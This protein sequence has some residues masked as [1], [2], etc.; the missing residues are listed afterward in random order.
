MNPEIIS[1]EI[2]PVNPPI[3]VAQLAPEE[4]GLRIRKALRCFHQLDVRALW[5]DS[6][7]AHVQGKRLI[8]RPDDLCSDRI[9]TNIKPYLVNGMGIL[10]TMFAVDEDLEFVHHEHKF[11][12]AGFRKT[13][14]AELLK[15]VEQWSPDY[16]ENDYILDD[17]IGDAGS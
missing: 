1:D 3:L 9:E 5:I 8:E 13:E 6:L 11:D 4:E 15:P 14:S 7:I 12:T 17:Y 2:S 16:D 10:L